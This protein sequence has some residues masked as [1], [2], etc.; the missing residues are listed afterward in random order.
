MDC[1]YDHVGARFWLGQILVP[2]S[3]QNLAPQT[4]RLAYWYQKTSCNLNLL[5][6]AVGGAGGVS[7]AGFETDGFAHGEGADGL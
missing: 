4:G 3:C 7:G 5:F 2:S 1:V 6:R